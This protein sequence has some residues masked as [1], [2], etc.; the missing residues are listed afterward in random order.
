MAANQ[1]PSYIKIY[2]STVSAQSYPYLHVA[3]DNIFPDGRIVDIGVTYG[4]NIVNNCHHAHKLEETAEVNM[5]FL[6]LQELFH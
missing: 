3:L 5:L 1:N 2:S 6:L 4:E